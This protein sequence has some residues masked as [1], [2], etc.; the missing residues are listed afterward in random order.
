M[1]SWLIA[2]NTQ[3]LTRLNICIWFL[4]RIYCEIDVLIYFNI[5]TLN[6]IF[7]WYSLEAF[8]SFIFI[9]APGRLFLTPVNCSSFGFIIAIFRS[10]FFKKTRFWYYYH[11]EEVKFGFLLEMSLRLIIK[12]YVRILGTLEMKIIL[13]HIYSSSQRLVYPNY[14]Q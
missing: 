11:W 9:R 5:I 6:N 13:S 1:I 7:W 14:K 4:F 2:W 3:C 8:A 12:I 10:L